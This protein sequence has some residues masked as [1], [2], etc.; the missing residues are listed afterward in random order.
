[1]IDPGLLR[2]DPFV[3]PIGIPEQVF[4]LGPIEIVGTG[5]RSAMTV[6]GWMHGEDGRPTPGPLGC[7]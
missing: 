7:F 5:A 3:T 4:G 2:S 6:A 1:M